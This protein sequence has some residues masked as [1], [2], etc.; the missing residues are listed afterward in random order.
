[1]GKDLS[2]Y[3]NLSYTK[4]MQEMNDESG[5]YYYVRILELDGCQSTGDT[6]EEIMVSLKEALQSYLEIRLEKG[7]NIPVPQRIGDYSGRFVVRLSR[8]LHKRLAEEA[9]SEGVNLNQ[10]ACYKLAQ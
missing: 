7:H 1:M 2:Y 9:S 5:H 4:L 6:L 3:M 8:I 10:W